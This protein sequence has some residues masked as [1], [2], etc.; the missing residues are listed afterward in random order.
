MEYTSHR[1]LTNIS[2]SV[3]GFVWPICFAIFITPLVVHSMGIRIFGIYTFINTGISVLGL[4]D[5]GLSAAVSKYLAEYHAKGEREKTKTL[6]STS[7]IIFFVIGLVG[8]LIFIFG[9]SI[10]IVNSLYI[11]VQ[12]YRIGIIA[13][14][15]LFFI[16]SITS[17]Y[18]LSFTS[19]QRFDIS[20]KIGIITLTIQQLSILTLILLGYSINSIFVT[21]LFITVISFFVQKSIIHKILPEANYK[22]SW[23]TAEAIKCYKFGLVT[24]T[25]NIATT[26]LT[27]LDRLIMPF[28]L[29]PS[30]LTYYSLPGNITTRIPGVANSLSTIMFPMTSSLN[31]LGETEKIKQLYIRSFRLIT[32][33]SAAITVTTISF[34]KEIL[35]YWISPDFAEKATTVL[36]VLAVTNFILALSGPLSSFLLGLGKL[37]FL[38]TISITMAVFNTILLIIFLPMAGIKGAAY[39]YLLS[40]LPVAFMFYFT[41]KHYLKLSN[42]KRYYLH[43]IS[44]NIAVSLIVFLISHY[45]TVYTIH[46][47]FSLLIASALTGIMY[48]LIYWLLGFFEKEDEISIKTFAFKIFRPSA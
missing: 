28:F 34:A 25:N 36:V 5:F 46:N 9:A 27:Y 12:P 8:A 15:I 20:S 6:I 18:S 11:E 30:N 35:T 33:I 41:E 26:S 37:K 39:A 10:P 14:G 17:I 21:I 2:W 47:L 31:G 32:V 22:L 29:G 13:A 42:R 48:I 38:T 23:D 24:F 1:A 7:K 3:L 4:I 40:L 44:G 43:M 45:L 16:T 19:L